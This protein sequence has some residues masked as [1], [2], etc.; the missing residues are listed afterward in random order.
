M[1]SLPGDHALKIGR[2]DDRLPLD[3]AHVVER[4]G[5][6]LAGDRQHHDVGIRD[7]APFSTDPAHLMPGPLPKIR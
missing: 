1:R 6:R 5:H 2:I 3:A 7:I 4:I